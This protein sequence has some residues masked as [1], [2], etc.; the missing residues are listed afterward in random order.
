MEYFVSGVYLTSTVPE[1]TSTERMHLLESRPAHRQPDFQSAYLVWLLLAFSYVIFTGLLSGMFLLVA[2][3]VLEVISLG[4][5]KESQVWYSTAC[6]LGFGLVL[7]AW[8][9]LWYLHKVSRLAP[10]VLVGY[11]CERLY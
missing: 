1:A 11:S 5:H 6:L 9:Q 10:P 4:F 2:K 3:S 8:I 7:S